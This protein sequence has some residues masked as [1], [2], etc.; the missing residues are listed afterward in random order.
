[1]DHW[2]NANYLYKNYILIALED[3]L[4]FVY[5][6]SKSAKELWKFLDRKYKTERV[7]SRN[8]LLAKSLIM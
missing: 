8:F 6:E 3:S 7:V 4:Y 5:N 2:K 1:M